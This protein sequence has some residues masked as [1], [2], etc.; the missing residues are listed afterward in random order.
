MKIT[1]T[2]LN[3]FHCNSQQSGKCPISNGGDGGL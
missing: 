3:R 2:V 1:T